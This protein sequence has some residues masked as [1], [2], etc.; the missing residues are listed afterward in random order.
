MACQWVPDAALEQ[1]DSTSKIRRRVFTQP[2]SDADNLR[3]TESRRLHPTQR[4]NA[5]A[6]LNVCEGPVAGSGAQLRAVTCRPLSL[7]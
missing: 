7:D 3:L 4:T 2:G 6:S 1:S 5:E